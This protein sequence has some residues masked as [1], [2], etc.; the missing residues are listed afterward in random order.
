MLWLYGGVILLLLSSGGCRKRVAAPPAE[1]EAAV[2]ELPAHLGETADHSLADWLA[3]PREEQARLGDEWASTLQQHRQSAQDH[4]ESLVLA[5][6]VAAPQAP[7]VFRKAAFS[8]EAGFS[9]PPYAA[10]GKHDA[11]LALHLARL[12]DREAALKLAD[13]GDQVLRA[14]IDRYRAERRYP[15]EWTRLVGLVLEVAQLKLA[16]GD[17]SGAT[18]LVQYH[19]QLK[20]ILDKKAAAG[21]LGAA[22]LPTGRKALHLVAESWRDPQ[23]NRSSLAEDV[24]AALKGWG[25]VPAPAPALAPGAGRDEVACLFPGAGRGKT[26]SAHNPDELARTLDLLELP[27]PAE[28]AQAVAAFLDGKDRLAELVLAYQPHSNNVFRDPGQ[29]AHHLLERGG[30]AE[31]PAAQPGLLREVWAHNGLA[32]DVLLLTR[33]SNVGAFVRISAARPAAPALFER[34]AR[35]FGVIS[36]DRSFSQNRLGLVPDQDGEKLVVHKKEALGRLSLPAALAPVEALQLQREAADDLLAALT[37]SWSAELEHEALPQVLV[38]LWRAYGGARIDAVQDKQG[39]ALVLTWQDAT[40][41]ARLRLPYDLKS[42]QLTVEDARGADGL[43]ARRAEADRLDGR[44]RAARIAA[45]KSRL[46]LPRV[47][48]V[49]NHQIEGIRLGLKRSEVEERIPSSETVRSSKLADGISVVLSNDPP[50]EATHWARQLFFRFGPDDRLAEARVRY[51]MGPSRPSPT[52]PALVDTLTKS[53]GPADKLPGPWEHLWSDLPGRHQAFLCR[54]QD[55]S[56]RLSFQRDS[57]SG[58]VIYRDCPPDRPAGVALPPLEFCSRGVEGCTLG[59]PRGKVLKH[60]GQTSPPT[61]NGADVL[62]MPEG[63]PYDVLL[64]WYENGQVARMVARHRS[65]HP[66]QTANVAGALQEAWARS[67]DQLGYVRHTEG[68]HGVMLQGYGWHDDHTRVRIFAQ[69][70][71]GGPRLFTE[72][73]NIKKG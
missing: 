10:A 70:V 23:W 21:P 26:F 44:E 73:R 65:P 50:I 27:L 55:D 20:D 41:R 17:A 62:S 32:Y 72:W 61:V 51:Q 7:L 19:K 34:S 25:D 30:L 18:E 9:L 38:P 11:A 52:A 57:T 71:E 14:A 67:F 60:W 37:L 36:L 49:N 31:K 28:G 48:D 69:Q 29:L 42:P 1:P 46:R 45:G 47:I 59:T 66:L 39:E 24:E 58:E 16:A 56:T 12:G 63:S 15:L 8:Q 35:D 22:L 54:W 13:P 53:A 3:L 2:P 4:P 68:A 40:T 33:G 43:A 5:P 64:V 6:Q